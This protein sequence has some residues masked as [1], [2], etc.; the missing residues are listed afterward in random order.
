M[1]QKNLPWIVVTFILLYIIILYILLKL[2]I[3][4]LNDDRFYFFVFLLPVVLI[5]YGAYFIF[6]GGKNICEMLIS[7]ISKLEKNR[8]YRKSSSRIVR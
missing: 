5:A 8:L 2:G 4:P 7:D 1:N 6:K 3:D